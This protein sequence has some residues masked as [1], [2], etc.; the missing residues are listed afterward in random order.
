MKSSKYGPGV[1]RAGHGDPSPSSQQPLTQVQGG[2]GDPSALSITML[3]SDYSSFQQKASALKLPPQSSTASQSNGFPL[4]ASP[5]CPVTV[6][7][8]EMEPSEQSFESSSVTTASE[9]SVQD[10]TRH[11]LLFQHVEPPHLPKA[12]STAT[13][14]AQPPKTAEV[15]ISDM[16]GSDVQDLTS[17]TSK[18]ASSTVQSDNSGSSSATGSSGGVGGVGDVGDVGGDGDVGGGCVDSD[19]GGGGDGVGGSL[20][21][22]IKGILKHPAERRTHSSS[23]TA[24][25]AP[26][27]RGKGTA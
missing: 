20:R 10:T 4:K 3:S 27:R 23:I 18:S 17:T 9:E 5:G 15:S 26:S 21:P 24:P 25:S 8:G 16:T 13:A 11:P 19:V 2:K 22:P 6:P 14:S 7:T 1:N 12:A